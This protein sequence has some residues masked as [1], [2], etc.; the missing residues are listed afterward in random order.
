MTL[1]AR[2]SSSMCFMKL[3]LLLLLLLLV[4]LFLQNREGRGREDVTYVQ[5]ASNNIHVNVTV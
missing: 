1:R 3:L 2:K 4:L 5:R